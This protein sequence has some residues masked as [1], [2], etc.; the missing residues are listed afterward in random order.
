MSIRVALWP[1]DHG[2]EFIQANLTGATGDAMGGSYASAW[3]ARENGA[4]LLTSDGKHIVY[5][6]RA[7]VSDVERMAW[8]EPKGFLV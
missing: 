1:T 8:Q 6:A 4:R 7:R 5:C 3:L 2:K